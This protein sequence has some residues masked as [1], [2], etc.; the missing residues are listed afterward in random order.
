VLVGVD[1]RSSRLEVHERSRPEDVVGGME[2]E[3]WLKQ[4]ARTLQPVCST[5]RV[6]HLLA[7]VPHR[8]SLAELMSVQGRLRW[9]DWRAT[10]ELRSGCSTARV[11]LRFVWDELDGAWFLDDG[12]TVYPESCDPALGRCFLLL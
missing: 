5:E 2:H 4:Y 10:L 7:A 11:T 12:V 8:R 3:A 6:V 1:P 9:F